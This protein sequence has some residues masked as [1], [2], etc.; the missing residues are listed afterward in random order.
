M[1]GLTAVKREGIGSLVFI[2]LLWFL[3]SIKGKICISK[4]DFAD[5]MI[6]PIHYKGNVY[7]PLKI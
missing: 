5:Q 3:R 2:V 7:I 6:K 1:T 4:I